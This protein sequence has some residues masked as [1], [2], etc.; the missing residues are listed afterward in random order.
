MVPGIGVLT[1]R[2]RRYCMRK[3]LVTL[4]L[5]LMLGTAGAATF[6]HAQSSAAEK[7]LRLAQT[8]APPPGRPGSQGRLR[9]PPAPE[10]LAERRAEMCGG[11]HA[12]AAGRLAE[13]EVRLEL[14][15]NQ[16]AAFN[17]WRDT[18]IAAAKRRAD[19][20]AAAPAPQGRGGRG[21]ANAQ[22]AQ[23]TPRSPVERM[24]RQEQLL[25]QR[26]T[27]LQAERPALEALYNSLSPEQRQKFAA[28]GGPRGGMGRGGPRARIG[29]MLRDRMGGGPRG[30]MGGGMRGPGGPMGPG[31]APP[32]PPAQ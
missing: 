3:S 8:Q 5:A 22:T 11:M 26:L 2:T 7:P 10:Q 21:P 30:P 1:I 12:R 6:A 24:A 15:A 29:M 27:D 20:C 17:K 18:R 4:S 9:A 14:T 23:A 32:P 13:L 19:A 31:M 25:R 16:R 28:V